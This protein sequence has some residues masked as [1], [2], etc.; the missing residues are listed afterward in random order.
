MSV[1]TQ[2]G[3]ADGKEPPASPAPYAEQIQR[4]R[5]RIQWLVGT[6]IVPRSKAMPLQGIT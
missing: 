6:F 4:S 3:D 1:D 5:I 2:E